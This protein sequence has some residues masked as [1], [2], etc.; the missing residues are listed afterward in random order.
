MTECLN[1]QCKGELQS[2]AYTMQDETKGCD[3]CMMCRQCLNIYQCGDC[4]LEWEEL[5]IDDIA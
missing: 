1:P 4:Y 5:V 3:E 2:L